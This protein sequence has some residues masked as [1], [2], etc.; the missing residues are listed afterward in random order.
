MAPIY[1]KPENALKV[2]LRM[3]VKGSGR[4]NGGD[5]MDGS[6]A[7]RV[8]M[9]EDGTWLGGE[10]ISRAGIAL[11]RREQRTNVQ[12]T[13]ELL[14]LKTETAKEQAFENLFEVFQSCVSSCNTSCAPPV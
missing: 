2:R 8:A 1:V 9:G 5:V 13:D 10:S 14:A 11:E 12:R 6:L 7:R 3:Q 4:R